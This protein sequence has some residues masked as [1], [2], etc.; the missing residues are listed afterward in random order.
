MNSVVRARPVDAV[1]LDA[2]QQ[3]GVSL[4]Q[5]QQDMSV[6]EQSAMSTKASMIRSTQFTNDAEIDRLI[7][8]YSSSLTRSFTQTVSDFIDSVEDSFRTSI[9]EFIDKMVESL[10]SAGNSLN[11]TKQ[12]VSSVTPS[13]QQIPQNIR[14]RVEALP[15]LKTPPAGASSR[16]AAEAAR[17][18]A[19]RPG[20]PSAPETAAPSTSAGRISSRQQATPAR[21]RPSATSVSRPG[22]SSTSS[23]TDFFNTVR[24]E[25]ERV[26]RELGGKIPPEVIIAQWTMETGGMIPESGNLGGVKDFSGKGTTMRLTTEM[27]SDDELKK[28]ISM[29]EEFVGYMSKEE[30]DKHAG[31]GAWE[32]AKAQNKKWVRVR[33]PFKDFKGIGDFADRYINIL[34]LPRY[35]KA[36]NADNAEDFVKGLKE[37][38][39]FTTD[40]G[41]YARSL[42]SI[43]EESKRAGQ[44]EGEYSPN[45]EIAKAQPKDRQETVAPTTVMPPKEDVSTWERI[46]EGAKR[47]DPFSDKG[48]V[49]KGKTISDLTSDA[50]MT[51]I[52]QQRKVSPIIVVDNSRNIVA[53]DSPSTKREYVPHSDNVVNDY[54][55]RL[56]DRVVV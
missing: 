7:D 4:N 55:K 39:Y 46:K 53:A 14:S 5:S 10:Q 19:T 56:V 30:V 32:T 31:A 27:Y 44:S 2:D 28:A 9:S 35:E 24:P 1:L 51:S 29:G 48:D 40:E 36:R 16:G 12:S 45:T 13:L 49:G 42:A 15:G 20:A 18:S 52:G 17:T 21:E 6:F 38:G 8:A 41:P 47:L 25:A 22:V 34:K 43:A 50:G 33:A 23:R 11:E 37:G 3:Q 26:S 54:R